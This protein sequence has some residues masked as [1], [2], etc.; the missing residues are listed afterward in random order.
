M[1][2][3]PHCQGDMVQLGVQYGGRDP[4]ER[5]LE[6]PTKGLGMELNS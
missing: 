5:E 1:Q 2:N 3:I 6:Q 4:R